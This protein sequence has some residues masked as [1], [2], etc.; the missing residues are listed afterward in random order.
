MAGSRS[1]GGVVGL[2]AQIAAGLF[3]SSKTVDHHVSSIL[4]KLGVRNRGAAVARVWELAGTEAT[5]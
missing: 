3:V 2:L 1:R 4:R 5:D